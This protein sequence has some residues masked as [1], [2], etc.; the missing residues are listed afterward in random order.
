MSRSRT[1]RDALQLTGSALLIGMSGCSGLG[2]FGFR[3]PFDPHEH[4]DDWQDEPVRGTADPIETGQSVDS[5]GSL[6]SLCGRVSSKAVEAAITAQ[7]T[8]TRAVDIDYTK[9]E[10]INDGEW[11]V[12]VSRIIHFNQSNEVHLTPEISFSALREATPQTVSATIT[13]DGQE[14]SCRHPVY[15]VDYAEQVAP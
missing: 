1:R 8:I 14:Y 9:A 7:V 12:M 3:E 10:G 4:V 15:L 6:K 5:Q 11:F 13:R 2:F